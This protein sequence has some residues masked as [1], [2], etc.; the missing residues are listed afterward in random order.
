MNRDVSL[1]WHVAALMRQ[2]KLPTLKSLV[3]ASGSAPKGVALK[4]QL[5]SLSEH[6]GIPMRKRNTANERRKA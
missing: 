1:A 5:Q 4:A 2:E 6:L 3:M